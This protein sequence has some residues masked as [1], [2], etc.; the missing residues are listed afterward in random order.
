MSAHSI[1]HIYRAEPPGFERLLTDLLIP[2]TALPASQVDRTIKATQKALCFA[3]RLEHSELAQW[4]ETSHRFKITHSAVRDPFRVGRT[5]ARQDIPW[6][7]ANI[8]HGD[9]IHFARKAE[10]CNE[11]ATDVEKIF[12][13]KI[14]FAIFIPLTIGEQVFG[15][16]CFGTS[17]AVA[18]WSKQFN[19][20]L[21]VIADAIGKA[22]AFNRT[23]ATAE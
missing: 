23:D 16:L 12:C 4:D 15:F 8:F 11:A 10:F 6:M 20:R 17:G 3:L 18:E 7:S 22:L 1:P 13:T 14:Q 21:R 19:D 9:V 5:L 2:F